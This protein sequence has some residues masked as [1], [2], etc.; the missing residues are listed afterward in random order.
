[1]ARSAVWSRRQALRA[2]GLG[3]AGLAATTA[4]GCGSRGSSTD[5]ST[6]TQ[7]NGWTG[8]QGILAQKRL[9]E[10]FNSEHDDLRVRQTGYP[11]DTLFSK[12]PTA[13][14]AGNPPKVV[15]LHITEVPQ[16]ADLGV[17]RPLD[18]LAADRGLDFAGVPGTQLDACSYDGKLYAVP[19]DQH[20]FALWY[21]TE[22]VERAGLDPRQPPTNLEDFLGW[23][24]ELTVRQGDRVEQYGFQLPYRQS[25]TARWFFQTLLNQFG[26]TFLTDHNRRCVVD[27]E[28]G[29]E[30]LRIIVD[31]IAS[32]RV[33]TGGSQQDPIAAGRIGIWV[34]GSWEL[35]LRIQAGLPFATAEMPRFGE[36]AAVWANSHCISL[37]SAQSESEAASSMRY[38][39]YF[40][41]NYAIPATMVG[42]IPVNP[43]ARNDER[44]TE[45][46][47]FRHY[48][49]F[50]KAL[51][52]TALEPTPLRYSQLFS[53]G[54]PTPVNENIEAALDR[55]KTVAAA[56]SDMQAGVNEIL[57]D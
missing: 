46:A 10:A 57:S 24:R 51:D 31:L 17:L 55:K 12:L 39:K 15:V 14:A 34:S 22:L 5:S 42:F 35:R 4:T 36:S 11:W 1:M 7:W 37:T 20:P 30:A 45:Q 2:L 38:A 27:S 44:L 25:T 43:R 13:A 33:A 40:Y 26:G 29:R 21:N 9:S 47:S 49:P 56:L 50:I 18:D 16:F 32:G 54:R 8:A 53:F 48:Q 6:I 3:T 19:G 41:D 23:V 28:A 52:Y